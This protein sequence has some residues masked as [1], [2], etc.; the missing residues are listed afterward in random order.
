MWITDRQVRED[1]TEPAAELGLVSLSGGGAVTLA[2]ERRNVVLCLPGGYH[3]APRRGETVLVVK[4]GPDRAPCVT[5]REDTGWGLAPGEVVLSVAEGS[6][7]RLL[8]GGGIRLVGD[9]AVEGSLTV[10]GEEV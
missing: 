6:E 3:W 5:G 10:N 1:L 4:S 7:V 8:P 9:V 2:G